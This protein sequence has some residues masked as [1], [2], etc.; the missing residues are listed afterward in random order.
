MRRSAS[1]CHEAES[2]LTTCRNTNARER[3]LPSVSLA[4]HEL[5]DRSAWEGL[6]KGA[7]IKFWDKYAELV[8]GVV[9][10]VCGTRAGAQGRIL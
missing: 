7:N 2:R 5:S 10:K 3:H 6:A 8:E 1:E 9:A 4:V